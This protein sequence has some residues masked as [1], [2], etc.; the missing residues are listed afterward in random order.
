LSEGFS[1]IFP[2]VVADY[3]LIPVTGHTKVLDAYIANKP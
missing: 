3:D 2:A 1:C